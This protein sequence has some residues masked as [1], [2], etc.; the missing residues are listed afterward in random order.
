LPTD[1]QGSLLRV[2]SVGKVQPFSRIV[3]RFL[4]LVRS[5]PLFGG[6]S[7]EVCDEFTEVLT[8][9]GVE[10]RGRFCEAHRAGHPQ[11]RARAS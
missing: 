3:S 7:S 11:A 9:F 10:I 6:I 2:F 5:A 4:G 8:Y 1:E